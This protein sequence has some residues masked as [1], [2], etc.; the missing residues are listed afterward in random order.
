MKKYL[1]I[2]LLGF[3]AEINAA[4]YYVLD[5]MVQ[6]D[7]SNNVVAKTYY[8]WNSNH[9][10][11][12]TTSYNLQDGILRLYSMSKYEYDNLGNAVYS[13]SWMYQM[14]TVF[15]ASKTTSEYD[16]QRKTSTKT[17]T[18]KK[19]E[20]IINQGYEY[21][22]D[23]QGRKSREIRMYN[24]DYY[25]Y[26]YSNMTTFTYNGNVLIADTSRYYSLTSSEWEDP[27]RINQYYY[28][29]QGRDTAII[30]LDFNRS[31]QS[32]VNYSKKTYLYED[33]GNLV[34]QTEWD[35]EDEQWVYDGKFIQQYS[36]D[37][38]YTLY[39]EY[40]D[41]KDGEWVG[42]YKYVYDY[43]TEYVLHGY[44]Q[45]TFFDGSWQYA[46]KMEYE[47]QYG[48][49]DSRLT[50]SRQYNYNNGWDHVYTYYSYSHAE[51]TAIEDVKSD[52]IFDESQPTY[53]LQ[54]RLVD[55]GSYHGIVIQNGHKFMR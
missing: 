15:W 43:D 33:N 16:G 41:F 46:S 5:S 14:D 19:G 45:Y 48:T 55:A 9:Q 36:D 35:F 31:S 53:D 28:D 54:G 1:F 24:Y 4:S 40:Y 23:N 25:G 3:A 22:Y 10:S 17:Y 30:E 47:F 42:T 34:T 32:W 52:V 29:S 2:L 11:T 26:T 44:I 12:K 7:A 6:V 38:V 18:Y 20:W 49:T 27:N 13:E 8:E 21:E 50:I 39:Y 51:D 37:H